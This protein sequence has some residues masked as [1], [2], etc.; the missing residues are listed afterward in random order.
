MRAKLITLDDGVQPIDLRLGARDPG[1]LANEDH[2]VE[3]RLQLHPKACR[4]GDLVALQDAFKNKQVLSV[5][6]QR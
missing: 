6:L 1:V 5:L 2:R 4:Q 3:G